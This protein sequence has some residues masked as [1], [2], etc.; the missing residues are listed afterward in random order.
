MKK[1]TQSIEVPKGAERFTVDITPAQADKYPF[2][3]VHE[4]N[5]D[6]YRVIAILLNDKRLAVEFV[7]MQ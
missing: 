3:S 1:K 7:K 5:D 6:K 2:L 4:F